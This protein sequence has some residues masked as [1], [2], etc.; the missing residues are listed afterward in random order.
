MKAMAFCILL[1]G[2]IAFWSFRPEETGQEEFQSEALALNYA[3]FRN[4]VFDYAYKVK[5]PGSVLPDHPDLVLPSGWKHIR[6]WEG[7]I[8]EES[9]GLYCYVFGPAQPQEVAAVMK[10]FNQSRDVGWNNGGVFVRNGQPRPLP[11]LIPH[12]AV[13][14]VIRID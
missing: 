3:I 1:L 11:S 6:P 7:H 5:T 10:L 4:A 12:G 14:S 8:Q 13:V 9:D 2:L